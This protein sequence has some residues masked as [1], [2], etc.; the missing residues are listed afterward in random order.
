[1]TTAFRSQCRRVTDGFAHF[2][3]N[4]HSGGNLAHLAHVFT[5]P[6]VHVVTEEA[7]TIEAI[8][9]SGRTV[10][11]LATNGAK[12]DKHAKKMRLP[13]G[14]QGNSSLDQVR[15]SR[16]PGHS[17]SR[18][19]VLRDVGEHGA[20]GRCIA[21]D[22]ACRDRGTEEYASAGRRSHHVRIHLFV[23]EAV[24]PTDPCSFFGSTRIAPF[25]GCGA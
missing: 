24:Q 8:D 21:V 11:V 2:K 25:L 6:V 19:A 7:P 13:V 3:W 9:T 17:P 4:V 1:M 22:V 20:G 16:P 18:R 10:Y 5:Q 14:A 12:V 15:V 23:N